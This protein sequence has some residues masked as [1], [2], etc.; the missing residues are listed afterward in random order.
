MGG[1]DKIRPLWRYYYENIQGIIFVIDSNDRDRIGI[2][3]EE[4]QKLVTEPLLRDTVILVLANKQDL[5]N[6]MN[7]S[8]VADKLYLHSIRGKKW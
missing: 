2:A 7:A 1:Q 3:R 8:E 5:D 4:I 6:S